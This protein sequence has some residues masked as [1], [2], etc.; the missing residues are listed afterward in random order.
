MIE[1]EKSITIPE[2]Y[3]KK[4]YQAGSMDISIL[5]MESSA[6]LLK[7][8]KRKMSEESPV[9]PYGKKLYIM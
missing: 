9:K 7:C 8:S 6:K 5:R 4:V 1:S 2:V 3:V